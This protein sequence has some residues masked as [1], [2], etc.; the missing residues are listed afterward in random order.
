MDTTSLLNTCTK[1]V[2][3]NC[4]HDVLERNVDKEL[5]SIVFFMGSAT[6][7]AVMAMT[8]PLLGA[9]WPLMALAIAFFAL[10]CLVF[11]LQ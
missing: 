6:E 10:C 11:R 8:I 3:I 5:K 1:T 4:V 7:I 2:L 9:L